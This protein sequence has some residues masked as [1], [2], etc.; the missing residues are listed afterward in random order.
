MTNPRRSEVSQADTLAILAG[1]ISTLGDGLATIAAALAIQEAQQAPPSMNNGDLENIQ[2]QLRA[3]SKE[4][5]KNK[6]NIEYFIMIGKY[7]NGA[8]QTDNPVVNYDV[9]TKNSIWLCKMEI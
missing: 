4:V 2:Q 7:K 9:P 3:L 5:K 6:K 8:A 1:L